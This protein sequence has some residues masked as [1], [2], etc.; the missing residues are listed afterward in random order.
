MVM[1]WGGGRTTGDG[2]E[3]MGSVRTAEIMLVLVL[4]GLMMPE[5][6]ASVCA[7]RW[8]AWR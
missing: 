2:E 3:E 1:M 7:E 6:C 5:L 8:R 4:V